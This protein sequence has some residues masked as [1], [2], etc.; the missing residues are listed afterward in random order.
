MSDENESA[1][2]YIDSEEEKFSAREKHCKLKEIEEDYELVIP[3]RYNPDS[4]SLDKFNLSVSYTFSSGVRLNNFMLS[5]GETIRFGADNMTYRRLYII[6]CECFNS[7]V[8]FIDTYFD[9]CFGPH[10]G[11]RAREISNKVKRSYKEHDAAVEAAIAMAK[12]RKDGEMKKS[13]KGYKLWASLQSWKPIDVK[14]DLREFSLAVKADIKR[15]LAIGLVPMSFKGHSQYSIN[16]RER[17]GYVPVTAFYASGQLID[18]VT[19]YFKVALDD[20]Q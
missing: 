5:T 12:W 7:G 16:L 3:T 13:S 6:L 18:H 15:C 2:K 4:L 1:D 8:R 9:T 14:A 20:D 19:L 10:M 17:L 11:R